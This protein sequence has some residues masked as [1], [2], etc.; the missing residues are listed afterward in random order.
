MKWYEKVVCRDIIQMR[1]T[2]PRREN[3]RIIFDYKPTG[4][5]WLTLSTRKDHFSE[6]DGREK[7]R[8]LALYLDSVQRGGSTP[9]GGITLVEPLWHVRVDD[10]KAAFPK[11]KK[12]ETLLSWAQRS[13]KAIKRKFP[14][15]F[16]Q[17]VSESI[18]KESFQTAQESLESGLTDWVIYT[19]TKEE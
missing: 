4:K 2:N 18:P 15:K 6:F 16:T 13:A 14:F 11:R 8:P 12:N 3:G 19:A 5:G 17:S 7:D 10:L 9:I 1:P